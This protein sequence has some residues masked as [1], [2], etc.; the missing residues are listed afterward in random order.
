M[1]QATFGKLK[2]LLCRPGPY[3]MSWTK[4]WAAHKYTTLEQM[5]TGLSDLSPT[6]KSLKV[7]AIKLI[8]SFPSLSLFLIFD[9]YFDKKFN[10]ENKQDIRNKYLYPTKDRSRDR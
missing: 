8:V 9:F 6:A 10:E 1:G 3:T 5:T 4:S 2:D 7:K